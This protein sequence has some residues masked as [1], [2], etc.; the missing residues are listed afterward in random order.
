MGDNTITTVT[1]RQPVAMDTKRR[2]AITTKE[3][4]AMES[5]QYN[6]MIFSPMTSLAYNMKE[7]STR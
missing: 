1:N 5:A 7:L 4:V 6:S 2:V 3:L